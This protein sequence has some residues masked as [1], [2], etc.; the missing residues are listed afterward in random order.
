[1]RVH[2]TYCDV[3]VDF[4]LENAEDIEINPIPILEGIIKMFNSLSYFKSVKLEMKTK[5]WNEE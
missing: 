2:F 1:M 4:V 5:D 3:D